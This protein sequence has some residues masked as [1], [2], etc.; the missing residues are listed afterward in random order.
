MNKKLVYILL[1]FCALAHDTIAGMVDGPSE[2]LTSCCPAQR[3]ACSEV[4]R[5]NCRTQVCNPRP[6]RRR[7]SCPR[8]CRTRVCR[9]KRIYCPRIRCC[10]PKPVCCAPIIPPC[11][12]LPC[13]NPTPDTPCTGPACVNPCSDSTCATGDCATNKEGAPAYTAPTEDFEENPMDDQEESM[14]NGSEE[15]ENFD[16]ENDK[17]EI[18]QD[19]NPA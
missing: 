11:E 3:P 13:V 6:Y 16:E 9:Q 10:R 19:E 15:M 14:D 7:I 17:E 8:P 4:R 2:E 18:N 5:L 1:S 12:P